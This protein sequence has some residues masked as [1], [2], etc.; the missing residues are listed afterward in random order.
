MWG[1]VDVLRLGPTISFL[2]FLGTLWSCQV[3]Q[4]AHPLSKPRVICWVRGDLSL[5]L[6]PN[7]ID[8]VCNIQDSFP[9][10]NYASLWFKSSRVSSGSSDSSSMALYCI[11]RTKSISYCLFVPSYSK[12]HTKGLLAATIQRV[13]RYLKVSLCPALDGGAPIQSCQ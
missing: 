8:F 4:H 5:Y 12:I 9:Q 1:L 10:S 11:Q 7:P 2:L 13:S 6:E 3:H